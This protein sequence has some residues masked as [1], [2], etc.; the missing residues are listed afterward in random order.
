MN[1]LF[2]SA[3]IQVKMK[4]ITRPVSNALGRRTRCRRRQFWEISQRKFGSVIDERKFLTNGGTVEGVWIFCRHGD[5]APSRPLCPAH[6]QDEEAEFWVSRLP[7][8]DSLEAFQ[9]FSRH[10][11]PD[12][13]PSNDG[14]FLDVR[15]APF[16]WLT[17]TGIEQTREN[18]ARLF[19]RYNR[20][21]QYVD[22]F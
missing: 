6:L 5:R 19:K 4:G 13:H 21:G 11:Q 8:P 17:H 9:A 2:L 12:V 18:G 10:F 3:E 16:G 20:L 1:K 14:Q 22:N 15:R 7:H